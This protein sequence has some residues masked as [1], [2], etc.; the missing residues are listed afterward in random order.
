MDR[1]GLHRGSFLLHFRARSFPTEAVRFT[2]TFYLGFFS[3]FLFGIETVTGLML[4]MHYAPTPQGAYPSILRIIANVPFGHLVRN[5]HRLGGEALLACVILH[6]LRVFLTDASKDRRRMTWVTGVLLMTTLLGLAFSGYLLPYDQVAY[7]AV[8][9]GTSMVEAVPVIGQATSRL[10]RGG[11]E[12]GAPGLLRFYLF[13]VG[14][15]PLICALLLGAH[16]YRVSRIHGISLPVRLETGADGAGI[17]SPVPFI[18]DML[19]RELSLCVLGLLILIPLCLYFYDAPL[20]HHADARHTPI[21]AQAP[22]FF[23]WVQG[24][25]KLGDKAVMGVWIPLAAFFGLLALPYLDRSPRKPLARRPLAVISTAVAGIALIGLTY[26]G[27]PRYGIFPPPAQRIFDAMAPEEGSGLLH[28]VEFADLKVGICAT[29]A[30]GGEAMPHSLERAFA[31]F[32]DRIAAAADALPN[33][34]GLMIIEDWQADLKRVT[35]RIVQDDPGGGKRISE[36]RII[37]IHKGRAGLIPEEA[38]P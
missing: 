8:T 34:V 20:S 37:H 7:W 31:G 21:N 9:I 25:L 23:L 28:R 38:A 10:L 3:V 1:I 18:P 36:E 22:W 30:P 5:L 32:R 2:H 35:L 27:T 4:M 15:L 33:P 6:L 16:Y 17:P 29:D 24:L 13:H 11:T 26:M 19:I 14:G 12:I